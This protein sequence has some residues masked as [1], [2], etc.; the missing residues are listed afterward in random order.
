[1]THDVFFTLGFAAF[2]IAAAAGI[3]Y[4]GDRPARHTAMYIASIASGLFFAFGAVLFYLDDHRDHLAFWAFAV[5]APLT[6]IFL[7]W[8]SRREE[9]RKYGQR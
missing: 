4:T 6:P 8:A 7:I 2:L 9:H 1:M 5:M 3:Y